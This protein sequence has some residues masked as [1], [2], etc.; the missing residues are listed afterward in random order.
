MKGLIEREREK[1]YKVKKNKEKR[2]R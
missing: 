1:V 2:L